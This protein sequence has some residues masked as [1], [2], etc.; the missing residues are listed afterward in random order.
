MVFEKLRDGIAV[1]FDLTEDQQMIR[2]AVAELAAKFDDEY[3]MAKDE[4]H[5]F[6]TEFY[7]A[8]ARGGWLGITTP[9]EYGGHGFGITEAALLLEEVSAAGGGMNAASPCICRSSA[10]TR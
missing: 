9:E 3:W 4:Q 7:E 1:D 5:Q 6:P 10:C 8:F 2:A